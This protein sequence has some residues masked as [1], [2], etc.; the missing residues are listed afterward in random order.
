MGVQVFNPVR[1]GICLFTFVCM[2]GCGPRVNQF[3]TSPPADS[4]VPLW[5]MPFGC[6]GGL[7]LNVSEV[8]VIDREYLVD[9]HQWMLD[10]S[11]GRVLR[12]SEKPVAA[13][14]LPADSKTEISSGSL[15]PL[16]VPLAKSIIPSGFDPLVHTEK[17]VFA[18]RSWLEFVFPRLV[19]HSQVIVVDNSSRKVV[20]QIEAPEIVVQ[21]VPNRVVVCG[22]G[23]TVGFLPLQS[24]PKQIID[25]YAAIH[26][27]DTARVA[28]LFGVWKQS[29]LYDLD[30]F[31]PLTLAAK[32]GKV[33][34]VKQLLAFNVSPNI[35]TADGYSPLLASLNLDHLE[36]A[37]LLLKAGADP[38]NFAHYWEFPLTRA[39]E[40]RIPGAAELLLKYGANINAIDQ[41]NGQTALHAAVMYRNYEAIQLLLGSGANPRIRDSDGKTPTEEV[42]PD[43]CISH[44][45]SG[46]K[47]SEKPTACAPIQTSTATVQFR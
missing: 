15:L 14:R 20:W 44:L 33:E 37:A 45:F 34:V 41:V 38:N 7:H 40:S 6:E 23:R 35:E 43:E 1:I 30:G 9:N 25:F 10:L 22:K 19:R 32:E 13:E 28:N 4:L 39:V 27:G 21:A 5:S 31:D 26:T 16:N 3:E 2:S 42:D 17:F 18:K 36:I 24:R 12:Q 11:T 47:V 46:G 8:S 29:P